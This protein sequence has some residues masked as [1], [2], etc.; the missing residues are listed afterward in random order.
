MPVEIEVKFLDVDIDDIRAR[1]KAAGA[2]LEHPMR[3][4]RRDQFDHADKR[5]GQSHYAERLRIRDE[6]DKCTM[7]YKAKQKDSPYPIEVETTIGSYEATKQLLEAIGLHSFSYQESK[8]ESWRLGEVEV[9]IDEWPW[10]KPYIEIEGPTEQGI[11]HVTEKL[12][13]NWEERR[14]G[15]ADTVYKQEYPKMTDKDSIGDVAD[16]RFELP[17][18]Q[19]FKDRM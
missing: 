9:V 13:F 16:V 6:G 8:R 12:G 15:S 7:T 17:I 10:V 19:Y 18:P 2:V 1:L 11:K 14:F 4:M 5:Y 3:L